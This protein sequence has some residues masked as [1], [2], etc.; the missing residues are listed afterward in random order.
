MLS[1]SDLEKHLQSHLASISRKQ[2]SDEQ[3]V[4]KL[5]KAVEKVQQTQQT[6]KERE[7]AVEKMSRDMT[8]L[9]DQAKT[10]LKSVVRT[11]VILFKTD[12]DSQNEVLH[13]KLLIVVWIEETK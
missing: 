13:Y 8:R 1:F 2:L 10:H 3:D 9:L 6:Y 7:D 4:H 12:S 5:A 11:L